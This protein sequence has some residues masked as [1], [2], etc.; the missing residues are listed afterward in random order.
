MAG[1]IP[2]LLFL[3]N[4]QNGNVYTAPADSAS[5]A[6]I[7]SVNVCNTSVGTQTFSINL[8][9]PGGSVNLANAILGN[10]SI[11]GGNVFSYETSIVIP[12]GASIYIS[13][14]GTALT[15]TIS[16]VEYVV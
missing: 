7:K 3:G 13:Q 2:K 9:L 1:I 12:A 15:F 11:S 14:P 5:Y 16:G 8:I 10:I 4:S 6:I